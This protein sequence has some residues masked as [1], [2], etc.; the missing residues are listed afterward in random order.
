MHTSIVPNEI[1]KAFTAGKRW[2]R[3]LS[4]LSLNGRKVNVV[5][6]GLPELID[7][8]STVLTPRIFPVLLYRNSLIAYRDN[9][10]VREREGSRIE[11]LL[12]P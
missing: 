9:C 11:E 4:V 6:S 12:T 10:Q 2:R 7:S 1:A 3:Q 8:A 5:T